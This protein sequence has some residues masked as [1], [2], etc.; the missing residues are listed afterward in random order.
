MLRNGLLIA[1]V[2]LLL[3]ACNAQPTPV[4]PTLVPSNTPLP[5]QAETPTPQPQPTE[6][7]ATFALP[8]TWT[9]TA[10]SSPTPAPATPT[11]EPT[12][13]QVTALDVCGTFGVDYSRTTRQFPLNT[14]PT[15]AWT[16]V[17][18]A[19]IYRISLFA[20]DANGILTTL[21][22]DV[23]VAETSYTITSGIF[24]F[25]VGTVYGWEVY[26]IDNLNRQMCLSRGAELIPFQP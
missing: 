7:V 18:G 13:P 22:D 2:G 14:E 10:I 11:L 23:Y 26:P 19:S 15:L 1:L 17:A 20:A 3:A 9:P 8:P 5:T 4:L 25:Q 12:I 24:Q 16:A 6:I 21:F